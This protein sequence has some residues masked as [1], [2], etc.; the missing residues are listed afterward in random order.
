MLC[1][2][3]CLIINFNFLIMQV[4]INQ[5]LAVMPNAKR[6]FHATDPSSK[7]CAEVFLPYLNQYME[8]Y[9][10]QQPLEVVYFLATIAVE[11]GELRYTEEIASG[12]AYEGRKDLGNTVK[13]YGKRFKGRG[14]IQ[15]TGFYNY[16]AYSD[17]IGYDFYSTEARAKGIAQPG[18]ATRS[19][20]WFWWKNNLNDLARQDAAQRIRRRVNGGLNGYA[21][22]MQYVERAKL[23]FCPKA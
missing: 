16:K 9:N 11:S 10:I 5:L 7:S 19:A 17:S 23:Q 1:K 2:Q 12:A 3:G 22:F 21:Q 13:G 8:K 6:R 20:C 15:I 4:T 14:L 18:N